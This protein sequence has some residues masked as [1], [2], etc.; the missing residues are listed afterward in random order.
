[1][2]AAFHLHMPFAARAALGAL[3][4]VSSI[5]VNG[6]KTVD[7]CNRV[8]QCSSGKCSCDPGWE[9]KACSVLTLGDARITIHDNS[10]WMW[11]G[12]F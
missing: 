12:T 1:M 10:T 5:G 7:D 3:L 11:G 6:C 2:I 8:G 4:L 9:G